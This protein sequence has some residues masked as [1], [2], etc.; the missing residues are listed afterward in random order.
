M[1]VVA[2]LS[3]LVCALFVATA[4]AVGDDKKEEVYIK[5]EIVGILNTGIVA[6]GGESTGTII[7]VNN[8]TWELDLG[9]NAKFMELAEKLEGKKVLA[10]GAYRKVKGV[11][12]KERHIVKVEELQEA[13]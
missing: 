2:L 1:R 6:I 12:I 10:K 8:V 11:E 13:K 7:K 4:P 3:W 5:V 9:G